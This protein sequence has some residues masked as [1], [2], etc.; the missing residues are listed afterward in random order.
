[1]AIVNVTVIPI[2][3]ETTGI[4]EYVTDIQNILMEFQ[5]EEKIEYK[6][7]PMSTIIQGELPVIFDIIRSIHEELFDKGTKRLATN[8]QIDDRR[9]KESIMNKKLES[10]YKKM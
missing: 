2:G 9:D 8:I 4:S 7:T 6:L 3:T 1:M 5:K 10:V